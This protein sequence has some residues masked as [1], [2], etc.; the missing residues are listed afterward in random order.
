MHGA[1][2]DSD[3][4]TTDRS[5]ETIPRL[6]G[7][8]RLRD[9]AVPRLRRG[10]ARAFERGFIVCPR[11]FRSNHRR[12]D[13][14]LGDEPHFQLIRSDD[15]ANEQIGGAVVFSRASRAIFGFPSTRF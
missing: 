9:G 10:D 7:R 6:S 5:P 2:S 13:D 8:A 14:V 4:L 1:R 12:V 3:W 15:V 11:L